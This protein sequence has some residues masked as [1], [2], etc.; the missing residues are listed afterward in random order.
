MLDY[1]DISCLHTYSV[2]LT[3]LWHE[4]LRERV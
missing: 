4:L 3:F 1:L 2:L